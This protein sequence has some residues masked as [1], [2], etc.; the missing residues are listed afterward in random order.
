[1]RQRAH[2][3]RGA[4]GRSQIVASVGAPGPMKSAW[5][6][7]SGVQS[8]GRAGALRPTVL[9]SPRPA[10]WPLFL[11]QVLA[12]M[13]IIGRYGRPNCFEIRTSLTSACAAIRA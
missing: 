9:T 4:D 2:F 13:M 6:A 11:D 3:L 10:L 7:S 1:M 8:R 5:P 12:S